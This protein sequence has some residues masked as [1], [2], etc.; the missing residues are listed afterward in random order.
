MTPKTQ[1]RGHL[2]QEVFLNPLYSR[3]S[4]PLVPAS[5]QGL[6]LPALE[7][8]GQCTP[9]PQ[10][11]PDPSLHRPVFTEVTGQPGRRGIGVKDQCGHSALYRGW[12]REALPG[13]ATRGSSQGSW[14]GKGTSQFGREKQYGP[15]WGGSRSPQPSPGV[16]WVTPPAS[17]S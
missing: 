8:T 9:P 12:R 15:S 17:V 10:G 3:S 7:G 2:L 5:S 6:L 14:K 4:T 13:M 11:A 1:F 16:E